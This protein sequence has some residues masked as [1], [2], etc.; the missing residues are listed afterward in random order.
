MDRWVDGLDGW[1]DGNNRGKRGGRIKWGRYSSTALTLVNTFVGRETATPLI[2]KYLL[3]SS[4]CARYY[5]R[6]Y[7]NVKD[8][9]G[10]HHHRIQSLEGTWTSLQ[11]IITWCNKCYDK[12]NLGC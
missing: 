7:Y 11:A 3:N 10:L 4:L 9:Q 1:I 8:R 6:K 2:I 5:T 12:G